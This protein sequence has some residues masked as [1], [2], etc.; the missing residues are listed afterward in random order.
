MVFVTQR[1]TADRETAKTWDSKPGD[2]RFFV[3][4]VHKVS[5]SRPASKKATRTPSSEIIFA[6]HPK[7]TFIVIS[8]LI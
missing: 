8:C 6:E 7:I 1:T 4:H 5:A 3:A 2:A